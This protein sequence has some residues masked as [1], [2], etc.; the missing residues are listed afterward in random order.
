[1]FDRL[2]RFFDEV[3]G[4]RTRDAGIDDPQVAAAALLVQVARADGEERQ[5]EDERLLASLRTAFGLDP[6]EAARVAEMGRR[7]DKEAVDLYRFTSIMKAHMDE[8]ERIAFVD[9]VWETIYADGEVHELEDN[10]V[11]RIAEL[12]GVS[13]RDRM[14]GKKRAAERINP[15]DAES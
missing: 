14:I 1:M 7:A 8:A 9:L 5:S 6:H 4:A 2:Q 11:W 10:L 13:S 3:S 12:L 15:E